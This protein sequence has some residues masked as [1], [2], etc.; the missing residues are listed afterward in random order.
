MPLGYPAE[1]KEE[2]KDSEFD[3]NKIHQEKW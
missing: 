1:K 2:H 3:L